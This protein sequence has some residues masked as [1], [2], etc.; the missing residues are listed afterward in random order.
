[1]RRVGAR[2]L[3]PGECSYSPNPTAATCGAPAVLHGLITGTWEDISFLTACVDH[4]DVLVAIADLT[5][6]IQPECLDLSAHW[7]TRWDGGSF[8]YRPED[9]AALRAELARPDISWS[10]ATS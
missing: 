7:L 2:D 4:Q 5:H 9:E 10:V 6:S 1:M 8:C 3:P